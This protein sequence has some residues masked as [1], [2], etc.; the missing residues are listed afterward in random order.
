M[1]DIEQRIREAKPANTIKKMNWAVNIFN[2]WQQAQGTCSS[3]APCK[4]LSKFDNSELSKILPKFIFDCRKKNGE[5]YPPKSLYEIY[6]MLNYYLINEAKWNI[7]ILND[8][9]FKCARTALE[10][11]MKENAKAGMVSGSNKSLFI[12]KKIE[13]NLW[14]AGILGSDSPTSL[15]NTV[16]FLIGV[17]FALRGGE[18]L[19][20]LR[21]GDL[22]QIQFSIDSNGSRCLIYKEDFSKTRQGGTKSIAI[23]PKEVCAF[24]NEMNHERCL[25]CLFKKYLHLRPK[26]ITTDALFLTP[27]KTAFNRTQWY[28]N[29]PLGRNL[30]ANVVKTI[31]VGY[32]G[33]YTNQSLR[34]TAATRLFQDGVSDDLIRCHT[35]HRSNAVLEYKEP[36][37]DQLKNIS[38]TLY[39]EPLTSMENPIDTMA[40]AQ[41]KE[42]I[43]APTSHGYPTNVHHNIDES[44]NSSVIKYQSEE[45]MLAQPSKNKE[46]D[47]YASE[48]TVIEL[49]KNGAKL[50]I[51]M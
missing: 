1:E 15:L 23:K 29:M 39:D 31:M 33:R 2:D 25:P 34:R 5:N 45:R 10:T 28:K 46:K 48:R 18:E 44:S 16:I 6:A 51:F 38:T 13:D 17:H 49:E 50:R 22:S 8:P 37:N 12:S 41:A 24:H 32:E 42:L 26:H 19:R 43:T 30:L 4:E 20:R 36:S 3:A 35:G 14:C 11:K 9:S 47:E 7:S 40:K 27:M 21:Y